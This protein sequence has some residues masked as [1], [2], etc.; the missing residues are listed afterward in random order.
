MTPYEIAELTGFD[1][2]NRIPSLPIPDPDDFAALVTDSFTSLSEFFV[3]TGLE[4]DLEALL[5]AQ[6]NAYHRL[7]AD[8]ERRADSVRSQIK[9]LD[10]RGDTSEIGTVELERKTDEAKHYDARIEAFTEALGAAVA[11]YEKQIGRPWFPRTGSVKGNGYTAARLNA[12]DYL[13]G[14]ALKKANQAF[15]VGTPVIAFGDRSIEDYDRVWR[16][17]DAFLERVPDLVLHHPGDTKGFSVIAAAWATARD[18]PQ[19]AWPPDFSKDKRS[20]AFKRNERLLSIKPAYLVTFGKEPITLNL[21]QKARPLN[22]Q[23][24]ER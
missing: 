11:C 12:R 24:V 23:I 1:D 22:I 4:G 13:K 17:L 14:A 6:T 3:N 15:P 9:E 19:V 5:W 16:I 7:I 21:I 8:L 20:A 2:G 18:R 10:E